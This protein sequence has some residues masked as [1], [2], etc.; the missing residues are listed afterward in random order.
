[1]SGGEVGSSVRISREN[2]DGKFEGYSLGNDIG[3]WFRANGVL[4]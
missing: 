3:T 1:M 2:E 4:I